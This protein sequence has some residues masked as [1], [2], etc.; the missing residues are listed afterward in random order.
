VKKNRTPSFL[1]PARDAPPT[2][3]RAVHWIKLLIPFLFACQLDSRAASVTLQWDR[4]LEPDIA[5]YR[6]YVGILSIKAGNPPLMEYPPPGDPPIQETIYTVEGLDYLRHY[7][8]V[9]TAVNRAGL[10]SGYSNELPV[11]LELP[12]TP[13]PTP[14]PTPTPT[15]S[16]TPTP[17]AS[18]T[19]SP[20]PTPTPSP[21]PKKH[22]RGRWLR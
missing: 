21:T 22:K 12:P 20:T 19:P 1:Q 10:E 17:T 16:P 15:P 6:V 3:L 13:T 11:Y 7:Y 9:V 14:S 2:F 8:F 5:F 18:P 4:N